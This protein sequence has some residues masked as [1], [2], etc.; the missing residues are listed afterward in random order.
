MRIDCQ[1][2]CQRRA[3]THAARQLM[4]I[5]AREFR[6]FEIGKERLRAALAFLRREALNFNAEHDVL[7]DGA[8]RQKQVLLQH[9]GDVGVGAGDALA[10][11][12]CSAFARRRQAR[13]DIKECALAAAGRTDERYDLRIVNGEAHPAHG[14]KRALPF[15][16]RETHR[17]VAVF[18]PDNGHVLRNAF[19]YSRSG[20]STILENRW[21]AEGSLLPP[22]RGS[23]ERGSRYAHPSEPIVHSP[24][25]LRYG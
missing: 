8:P 23:R 17:D 5:M 12:E 2:A 3:L 21:T 22:G 15:G 13:A 10:V 16:I 19:A 14:R 25:A 11:D 20:N 24:R 6:K 9:K 7:G 4:W 1:R 18:E